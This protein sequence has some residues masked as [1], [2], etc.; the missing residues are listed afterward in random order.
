MKTVFITGAKG[1]LGYE[2]AFQYLALGY[3]VLACARQIHN[4][5]KLAD[6]KTQYQGQ[7]ELF[8]LDTSD[9]LEINELSKQLKDI[10]IDILINNAGVFGKKQEFG[11]IDYE[12]WLSVLRTNTL[13]PLKLVE[14]L[15]TNLESAEGKKVVNITSKMASIDDNTSGG[16]YQYRSSKA[17]LNMITKSLSHDLKAKQITLVLLHPG[18]VQTAMGGSN[19]PTQARDS[20]KGMIEIISRASIEDTGKFVDFMN[21]EIKW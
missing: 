13:G 20:V 8:D 3:K 11:N 6:L 2:F 4:D 7:L 21:N 5:K 12:E 17:A 18:W 10:P 1:G 16:Y 15:I 19:A 9:F 14:S